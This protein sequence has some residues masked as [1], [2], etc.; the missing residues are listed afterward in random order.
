MAS[1]A[2][3]PEPVHKTQTP[4]LDGAWLDQGLGVGSRVNEF[5][6][7]IY[8]FLPNLIKM[9]RQKVFV[10]SDDLCRNHRAEPLKHQGPIPHGLGSTIFLG[11]NGREA[12]IMANISFFPTDVMGNVTE[13]LWPLARLY[14]RKS[15]ISQ[16]KIKNILR[17]LVKRF[18]RC[19][20]YYTRLRLHR[21]F[22]ATRTQS[23]K[24]LPAAGV[25]LLF[26]GALGGT[27]TEV[28]V[29]QQDQTT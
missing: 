9:Y 10:T 1:S 21:T 6:S 25:L 26:A 4:G 22:V 23:S 15:D 12:V 13:L 11:Q 7:T 3:S 19:Q 24:V 2:R 5:I 20:S 28:I 29:C 8:K 16:S 17:G 18:S 14:L 27:T